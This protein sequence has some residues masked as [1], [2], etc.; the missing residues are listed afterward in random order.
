MHAK[1][2]TIKHRN[3]AVAKHFG[4]REGT[5]VDV[6]TWMSSCGGMIREMCSWRVWRQRPR[7]ADQ[8]DVPRLPTCSRWKPLR[9]RMRRLGSCLRTFLPVCWS[10]MASWSHVNGKYRSMLYWHLCMRKMRTEWEKDGDEEKGNHLCGGVRVCLCE[11]GDGIFASEH[12]ELLKEANLLFKDLL[13]TWKV[14]LRLK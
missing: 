8:S 12:R 11:R 2:V 6:C 13:T 7:L 4:W 5:T 9:W 1:R 3:S 14:M 10:R